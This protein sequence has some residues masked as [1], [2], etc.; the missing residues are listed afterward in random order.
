[1]AEGNGRVATGHRAAAPVNRMPESTFDR[2][3][4]SCAIIHGYYAYAITQQ[5]RPYL[6]YAACSVLYRASVL[7]QHTY[8]VYDIY[9][10]VLYIIILGETLTLDI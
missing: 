9:T 1:V 2:H 8:H 10:A 4:A 7:S 5:R 3:H 6:Q